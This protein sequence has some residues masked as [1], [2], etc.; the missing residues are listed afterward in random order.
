MTD[1]PLGELKL[2]HRTSTVEDYCD[3]LMALACRNHE[4][5][6][7]QQVQLF[8]AGL[9][10]PLQIDV[11]LRSPRTMNEA[12]KLARAYEQHQ[13][14]SDPPPSRPR[15][16]FRPGASTAPTGTAA[17]SPALLGPSPTLA[18][19]AASSTPG[20]RRL[21]PSEM[22]H[23]RAAGLCYNCDEKF[24]Y[25]HKCKN[26]F[27]MEIVAEEL[28][29]GDTET[30]P[31]T[32]ADDLA[33]SLH[34]FTGIRPS[35]FST[36]KVWVF[37]GPHRL[38]TLLDSGF[39]HN[40]IDE[41]IAR[42]LGL[43]LHQR[44]GLH[45]TVGDGERVTCSGG[46]PDTPIEVGSERFLIDCY[47]IPVGGYDLILGV[48]F[49]GVLGPLLW[50]FAEQTLCFRRDDCQILWPGLDR[51]SPL[52]IHAIQAGSHTLMQDL[53]EEFSDLFADPTGLP[54]SRSICHHIWLYP[55]TDA[56]AVRPYRYAHI[57][58]ELE[59]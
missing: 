13:A 51:S 44:H 8:V 37:I 38:T 40:L 41:G 56:V 45:V 4:L 9:R 43:C 34:A 33:L 18:T 53:L 1:S 28:A 20:R 22:S 23:H 57:Q 32:V 49:L 14:I 25:G 55:G 42:Q 59:C 48:C 24:V 26:L 17:S 30:P 11:A 29:E 35:K 10:N 47:A 36:M 46:F 21:T 16:T 3:R 52:T 15:S 27:I 19:S 31:A 7:D 6:E 12:I 39:S 5:S 2:L 54:P 50:D 58:K